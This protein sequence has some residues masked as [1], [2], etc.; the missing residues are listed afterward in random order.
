MAAVATH[1]VPTQVAPPSFIRYIS[2]TSSAW[3]L[4]PCLGH[5]HWEWNDVGEGELAVQPAPYPS[6]RRH[7]CER[8]CWFNHQTYKVYIGDYSGHPV[9]RGHPVKRVSVYKSGLITR[10]TKSSKSTRYLVG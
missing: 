2:Y 10:T 3:D 5:G 6:E 8:G 9:E 7:P 4:S 1:G